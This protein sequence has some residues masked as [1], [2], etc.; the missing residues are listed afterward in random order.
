MGNFN[1]YDKPNDRRSGGGGF[2]RGGRGGFDK[3]RS[4]GGDRDRNSGPKE[5]FSA[6]CADCGKHCEVPFKPTGKHPVYCSDCFANQKGDSRPAFPQKR[7]EGNMGRGSNTSYDRAPEK[8]Y[9]APKASGVT[10]EQFDSLNAKLDK[11]VSLLLAQ[12]TVPTS[13]KKE[14]TEMKKEKAVKK[15]EKKE[16]KEEKKAG[17]KVAKTKP[18]TAKK[19]PTKK[20]KK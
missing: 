14:A 5:M 7:F 15:T 12:H 11:I 8:S 19:A 4:F 17:K 2:D 3:K 20:T 16:K 9:Q 6:T 13:S 18:A 1:R 10:K